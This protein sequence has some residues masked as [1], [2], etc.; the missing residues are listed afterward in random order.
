MNGSMSARHFVD[1]ICPNHE[2]TSCEDP[3][4]S[5]GWGSGVQGGARCTRCALLESLKDGAWP[6]WGRLAVSWHP[7]MVAVS[8]MEL[9][10]GPSPM[11]IGG[12]E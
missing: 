1:L 3:T 11:R 10:P 6:E 12:A 4:T 9:H 2:R 8:R 5:N 7:P